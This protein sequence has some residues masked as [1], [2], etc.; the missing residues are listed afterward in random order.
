MKICETKLNATIKVF[1]FVSLDPF[2]VICCYSSR[3]ANRKPKKPSVGGR[4]AFWR[5]VR[6]QATLGSRRIS[7]CNTPGGG[8][9]AIVPDGP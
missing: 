9:T 4:E 6:S 5:S 7:K 8:G 1:I 3:T 2:S